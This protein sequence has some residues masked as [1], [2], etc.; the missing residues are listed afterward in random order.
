MTTHEQQQGVREFRAKKNAECLLA[1][2]I[3]AASTDLRTARTVKQKLFPEATERDVWLSILWEVVEALTPPAPSH[4]VTIEEMA[5]QAADASA[6]RQKAWVEKI[7]AFCTSVA[8]DGIIILK[9]GTVPVVVEALAPPEPLAEP[10]CNNCTSLFGPDCDSKTLCSRY[11]RKEPVCI[12][13]SDLVR[14]VTYLYL[15]LPYPKRVKIAS[16]MGLY[17]P[18]DD[19]LDYG[20]Q[21]KLLLERVKEQDRLIE[22]HEAIKTAGAE[23]AR[24]PAQ[25]VKCPICDSERFWIVGAASPGLRCSSCG[26]DCEVL[27][28]VN[29]SRDDGGWH[30]VSATYKAPAEKGIENDKE[31]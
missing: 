27:T 12:K 18:K 26:E 3:A 9:N 21:F 7:T 25:A 5:R 13:P 14:R 8:A 2:I 24:E 29:Y 6:T 30:N 11:V 23:V 31:L 20:A 22:F 19:R 1:E 28:K 17:R 16:A 10:D 15:T 4:Q